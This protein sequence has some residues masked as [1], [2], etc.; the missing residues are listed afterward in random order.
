M[1]AMDYA[2]E[3]PRQSWRQWLKLRVPI[4]GW[5]KNYDFAEDFTQDLIAGLSVGCLVVPQ[6]MAHATI[7]G[8]NPVNGLYTAFVPCMV[9]VAAMV[10]CPTKRGLLCA[11]V[12]SARCTRCLPPLS[13]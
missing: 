2:D 11:P 4:T 13:I 8:V 1:S 6:S 3:K 9:R 5:L 7:A 10:K 12:R